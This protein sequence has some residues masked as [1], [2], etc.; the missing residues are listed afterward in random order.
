MIS[1]DPATN[2]TTWLWNAGAKIQPN[3]KQKKAKL[4]EV[5]SDDMQIIKL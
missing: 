5:I 3:K 1:L 4:K 2:E